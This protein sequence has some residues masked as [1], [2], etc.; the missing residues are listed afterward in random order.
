MID[1]ANTPLVYV[2]CETTGFSPTSCRMIEVAAIRVENGQIV[3]SFQTLLRFDGE[4]PPFITELTGIKPEELTKAIPFPKVIKELEEILDGAIFVAHNAK[5]D[6]SFFESEF[7]RI[8]KPFSMN[9][10]CT[11]ELA[12]Y[13]YPNMKNHKLQ[14][15]IEK[16]SF[17][18]TERHRAYDDANVLIQF[19]AKLAEEFGTDSLHATANKVHFP[20]RA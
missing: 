2:D 16:Y 14:T 6:Y 19:M 7:K 1:I 3:K 8:G 4:L 5:F 9:A 15:L 13:Y 10:L 18:F 11:V 20:A 17:D 12:R